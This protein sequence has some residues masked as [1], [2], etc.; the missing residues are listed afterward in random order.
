ML[1]DNARRCRARRPAAVQQ[2]GRDQGGVLLRAGC[3]PD[4]NAVL[5]GGNP[6]PKVPLPAAD[7]Q[8]GRQNPRVDDFDTALSKRARQHPGA[9]VRVLPARPVGAAR[10]SRAHHYGRRRYRGEAV[11]VV[12]R[13]FGPDQASTAAGRDGRR[14]CRQGS[15]GA[16]ACERRA[17]RRQASTPR[18]SLGPPRG[19]DGTDQRAPLCAHHQELR[20][21][22]WCCPGSGQNQR[23][24]QEVG[25]GVLG[26]V[27]PPG[28]HRRGAGGR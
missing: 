18:S 16:Q 21:A 8:R 3:V 10:T 6:L 24:V 5:S 9:Y 1:P 11:P 26:T 4:G 20:R 2:G 27:L 22:H 12:H 14:D 28:C 23:R 15:A 17:A 7:H 25:R 19:P 13:A